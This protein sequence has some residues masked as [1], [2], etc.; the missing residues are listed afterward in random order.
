[1]KQSLIVA[2]GIENFD[3]TDLEKPLCEKPILQVWWLVDEGGFELLIPHILKRH[4]FFGSETI[5]EL[6]VLG[7]S[8]DAGLVT[9]FQKLKALVKELRLNY[10]CDLIDVESSKEPEKY[11]QKLEKIHPE[12]SYK[13]ASQDTINGL[14]KWFH[15]AEQMDVAEAN[16]PATIKFVTLPLPSS[17]YTRETW[18]AL[19]EIL[20][21]D[22]TA[23]L[24]VRGNHQNALT[25]DL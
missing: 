8:N 4:R 15:V 5:L 25:T 1:M 21:G 24:F 16:R 23:T 14:S 17:R 13:D 10:E 6:K 11:F 2:K 7:D 19:L 9:R 3:Y 12:F 22:K 18:H 20:G